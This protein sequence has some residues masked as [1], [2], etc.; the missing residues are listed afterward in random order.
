MRRVALLVLVLP[1]AACGGGKGTTNPANTG[2]RNVTKPLERAIVVTLKGKVPAVARLRRAGNTQ[3]SVTLQL[4]HGAGIAK[5]LTAELA[6][7][8]CG[9][10]QGLQT[11]KPL[12]RVTRASQSWSVTASLTWLTA[13]PLAVV[14]RSNRTIVACGNAR[15]A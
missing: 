9:S 6:K 7:G 4:K 15:Q 13:S 10:P 11:T 12:G 1:L 14:L 2:S 5:R 8:S 3:T